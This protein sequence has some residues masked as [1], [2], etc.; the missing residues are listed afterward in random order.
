MVSEVPPSSDIRW[1]S[2]IRC[3]L[4]A[5]H[6]YLHSPFHPH[7][8]VHLSPPTGNPSDAF[9]VYPSVCM[10]FCEMHIFVLYVCIFNVLK[11]NFHPSTGLC[12]QPILLWVHLVCCF[13]LLSASLWPYSHSVYPVALWKL[14]FGTSV[15]CQTLAN[16]GSDLNYQILSSQQPLQAAL[17]SLSYGRGNWGRG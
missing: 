8:P 2:D 1:D 3:G 16:K 10:S 11:W 13:W 17:L 9:Y 6:S 4:V 15:I 7:F 12:S 14:T 5:S